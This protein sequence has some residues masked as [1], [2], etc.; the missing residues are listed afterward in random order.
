MRRVSLNER[1][2]LVDRWPDGPPPTAQEVARIV[3]RLCAELTPGKPTV[4]VGPSEFK[5]RD[6]R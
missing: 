3:D 2:V 5:R 4:R 6:Q 1:Y